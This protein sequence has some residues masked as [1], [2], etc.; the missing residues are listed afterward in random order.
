MFLYCR[1]KARQLLEQSSARFD[2]DADEVI[3]KHN[4]RWTTKINTV[5]EIHDFYSR[6]VICHF[7]SSQLQQKIKKLKMSA[8]DKTKVVYLQEYHVLTD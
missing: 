7:I 6:F 4:K 2:T 3:N 5:S 8:E 1:K